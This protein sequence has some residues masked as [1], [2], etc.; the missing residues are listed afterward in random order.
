ML[1]ECLEK[2]MKS[3]VAS[4]GAFEVFV[5]CLVLFSLTA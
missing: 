5:R 2:L 3:E 4:A 1:R